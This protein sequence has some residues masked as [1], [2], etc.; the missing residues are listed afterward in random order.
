MFN[1][2]TETGDDVVDRPEWRLIDPTMDDVSMNQSI[3]QK[4]LQ[5]HLRPRSCLH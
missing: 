3:K 5:P 4:Y 2:S 1:P